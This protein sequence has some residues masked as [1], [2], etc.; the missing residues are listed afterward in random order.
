[1]LHREPIRT[2]LFSFYFGVFVMSLSQTFLVHSAP[3]LTF[4]LP[5][6]YHFNTADSSP[7]LPA[8]DHLFPNIGP[9]NGLLF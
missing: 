4:S 2:V 1:M 3:V 8:P 7:P 6:S 5:L 9:G